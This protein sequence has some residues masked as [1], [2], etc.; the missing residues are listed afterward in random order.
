LK[1]KPLLSDHGGI[2]AF[3]SLFDGD[4]GQN[5]PQLGLW[6]NMVR[7]TP[8]FPVFQGLD[9]LAV[10]AGSAKVRLFSQR[11]STAPFET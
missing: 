6:R 4:R 9:G 2:G 5:R 10:L 11:F 8:K 7:C 3:V 1:L